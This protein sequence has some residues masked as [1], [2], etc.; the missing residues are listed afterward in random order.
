M[1]LALYHPVRP[2]D[3]EAAGPHFALDQMFRRKGQDLKT[4]WT[5]RYRYHDPFHPGKTKGY[6]FLVI[7][8]RVGWDDEPEPMLYKDR[9]TEKMFNGIFSKNL[10]ETK[11]KGP[12]MDFSFEEMKARLACLPWPHEDHQ[13]SASYSCRSLSA[14][15]LIVRVSVPHF[16]FVRLREEVDRKK[17][18]SVLHATN[19]DSVRAEAS[20]TAAPQTNS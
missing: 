15:T 16:A 11:G 20:S 3:L 17:A 18:R 9:F 7:K 6:S 14:A 2:S 19:A 4:L 8:I 12:G 1:A 5:S 13:C 10:R